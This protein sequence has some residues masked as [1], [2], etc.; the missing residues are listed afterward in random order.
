MN[1]LAPWVRNSPQI[2]VACALA[3]SILSGC[4]ADWAHK[5]SLADLRP[6]ASS[7]RL[8]IRLSPCVDRTGTAGR[9]LGREATEAFLAKLQAAT[10]FEISPDARYVV[11]C[12]VSAFAE[13]S[14]FKRWLMPGWGA[15]AGQVA[16]MV[17]DSRSGDTIAIIRGNATVAGGGL[18]TIGADRVI[19]ASALDDVV[20]QMRE[21]AAR[22]GGETRSTH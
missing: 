5:Q 8:P 22:S 6:I 20:R 2:I 17:T 3:L 9:D 15:T 16:V 4:A 1:S 13:G 12:D 11:N 7:A 19:L 10:E 18:Y 14:A 21:L